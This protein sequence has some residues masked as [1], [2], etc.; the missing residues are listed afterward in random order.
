MMQFLQL[1]LLTVVTAWWCVFSSR[2]VAPSVTLH[3]LLTASAHRYI[4][5]ECIELESISSVFHVY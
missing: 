2:P 3:R 1:S 5:V 4:A